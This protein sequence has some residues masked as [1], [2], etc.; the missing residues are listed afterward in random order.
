M[1]QLKQGDQVRLIRAN[2]SE[3]DKERL[4]SHVDEVATLVGQTVAKV[5]VKFAEGR[6]FMLRQDQVEKAN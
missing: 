6:I 2:L 5:L 4:G 3:F 1:T